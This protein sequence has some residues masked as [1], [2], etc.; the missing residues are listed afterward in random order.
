MAAYELGTRGAEIEQR[1]QLNGAVLAFTDALALHPTSDRRFLLGMALEEKGELRRAVEMYDLACQSSDS[2]ADAILRYDAAIK[3]ADPLAN[4]LSDVDRAIRHVD[5]AMVTSGSSPEHN[6][7]RQ[8]DNDSTLKECSDYTCI[9]KARS[10]F[11]PKQ[12]E[13]NLTQWHNNCVR[14]AY[15][16][17]WPAS[18]TSR[19]CIC[20]LSSTL[21]LSPP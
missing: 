3:L 10:V 21:C 2:G 12:C 16:L 18:T 13:R 5:K 20:L 14:S 7:I 4:D 15:H 17:Y 11:K 8:V 6:I 1:G 9:L 19:L